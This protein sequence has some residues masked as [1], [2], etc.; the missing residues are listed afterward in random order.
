MRFY[1]SLVFKFMVLLV[2]VL[3]LVVSVSGWY[4]VTRQNRLAFDKARA[5]NETALKVVNSMLSGQLSAFGNNLSLLATVP[6][7]AGFDPVESARYLKSY[8]V[9]ALFIAGERLALYDNSKRLVSDNSMVG[10]Y[11]GDSVFTGRVEPLRPYVGEVRWSQNAPVL[12]FAATVQNLAKAN[13]I[14]AADFSFKRIWAR[15]TDFRIGEKGFVVLVDGKGTVLFHPDVRKWLLKPVPSTMLGIPGFDPLH[16]VGSESSYVRLDDGLEYLVS[17]QYNSDYRFGVLALQPR[18]QIENLS[19]A[20]RSTFLLLGS[21][22]LLATLVA[23][24][25]LHFSISN[26]LRHLIGRMKRVHDG[27]LDAESGIRNHDEIGWFASE[28]DL[29]RVSLRNSIR[30]LANHKEQLEETVKARTA[31]LRKANHA[32]KLISHTDHLTGIPNRRDIMEKIHYEM[33]RAQRTH[34]PF[35]FLFADID[36]FKNFNDTYGHECGDV[37]LKTVA[38][39]VRSTL[40]KPDYIARWGGEEFLVVLPETSIENATLVAERVR[41]AV[42]ATEFSYGGH[43]FKVTITL[44]VSLFDHRL[45]IEYSINLADRALYRGKEAG[46]NRVEVWNPEDV[47]EAELEAARRMREERGGSEFP[48]VDALD[49]DLEMVSESDAHAD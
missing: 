31:A 8:K 1:R 41:A 23:A 46:R 47:G 26:P 7:L 36:K 25:W 21:L 17:Y 38:Q 43:I 40:R 4:I 45:G 2:A 22:V 9:S 20:L 49:L 32:L 24:V 16:Y 48:A 39:V 12:P 37:V 15:L 34:K 35:S 29:M 27:D 3:M 33:F 30:E 28:F 10:L 42:A 14:L 5:G 44:G 19:E 6:A 18:T 11:R 13:G